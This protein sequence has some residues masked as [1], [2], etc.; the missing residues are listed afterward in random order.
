[1]PC[2]GDSPSIWWLD[3]V[4]A[5]FDLRD[6]NV[7]SVDHFAAGDLCNRWGGGEVTYGG[8]DGGEGGSP[9]GEGTAQTRTPGLP[10]PSQGHGALGGGGQTKWSCTYFQA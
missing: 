2:T 7:F 6:D 4:N 10:R 9:P 8:V 1:M 5:G 3:P